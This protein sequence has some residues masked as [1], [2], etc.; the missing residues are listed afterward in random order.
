MKARTVVII[1]TVVLVFYFVML[2]RI[3]W[4]L[5]LDGS[6]AGI[7]L[8]IG[9][10]ILPLVGAILIWFELRFGWRTQELGRELEAEGGLPVAEGIE[11]RPSGRVDKTTAGAHFEKVKAETEAA[12]LEWQSWFRLSDAYELAGDRKRAREAMRQ[13]IDLHG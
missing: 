12:P 13:A 3:G 4:L 9:I 8:G 5:L 1:L 2:G 10:L 7:G 6:F 11:L